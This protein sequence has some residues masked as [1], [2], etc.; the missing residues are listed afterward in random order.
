MEKSELPCVAELQEVDVTVFSWVL[1]QRSLR[2]DLAAGELELSEE[3][4]QE[5]IRRLIEARLVR[6]GPDDPAAGFAVAPE[7]ALAHLSAP[8]E[9]RIREDQHRVSLLR[10]SLDR[11]ATPYYQRGST[12]SSALEVIGSL[13]EVRTAL[14]LVSERCQ[15]EMISC[16]PGGGARVPE[17]MQ[18]AIHR[19]RRLLERGVSIR[20]L[21]HH[22]ARFNAPSQAY[23][24]IAS[25]LG[26]QYRTA[27]ALFGR[28]IAF[29]RNTAF[30]PVRDGTWGAVV[31]REPDTVA[32]LCDIFEHTWETAAPFAD[33]ASDGLEQVSREMH[34]TIVR[35]LAAGLKDEAIARRLG[36]SLRTAR[37]HVAEIMQELNATSRF[38]AGA[39]A[40]QKGLLIPFE[41]EQL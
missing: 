4:T 3:E 37:R 36:M 25:A 40:A 9:A 1:R 12:D 34:E 2:A 14:D 31:I 30:I 8:F 10:E 27:H 35:L 11:F 17:A 21:Y 5:S 20:T 29:D 33:A 19:D 24:A 13:Q 16:Q 32:Y 38:Q 7:V 41:A 23:V 26:G 22:T 28:L 15:S 18:E 6:R 39:A